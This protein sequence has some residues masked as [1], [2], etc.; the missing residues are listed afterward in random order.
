MI[1]IGSRVVATTLDVLRTCGDG[2]RECI[3]YWVA[4]RDD[5]SV[6][7]VVHP[8]HTACWSGYEVEGAW[9]TKFFLDLGAQAERVVAQVHSH[10]GRWVAMSDTDDRHVL[11]PSAGFI[12]IVVP[13]FALACDRRGWGV[14][15]LTANGVWRDSS[16]DARWTID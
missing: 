2:A 13:N 5:R 10:P 15:S 1:E 11:L 4:G 7:R 14:W 9:V 6:G 16:E 3:V 8:A 12:S